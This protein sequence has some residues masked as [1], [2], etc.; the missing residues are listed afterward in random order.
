MSD[1]YAIRIRGP[2]DGIQ[3]I[4]E[5][6]A[7]RIPNKFD[8]DPVDDVQ[9]LCPTNRGPLGARMLNERLQAALNPQPAESLEH[10]GITYAIGD[11]VM[12]TENDYDRD[13]YNGDIGRVVAVDRATR[14]LTVEIDGRPIP[15]TPDD[16]DCLVPAYAIT[17]HK[18][19]GSEYPV[20]VLPL[21]RQ[22][23]RML[24]RNL[25]YTAVTRARRLVVVLAQPDALESAITARPQLRRIS[26]LRDLLYAPSE[27]DDP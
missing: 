8:L 15:Y 4:L 11:K 5:V 19:Q 26:R 2:D 22:Y 14:S 24:R 25:V 3:K 1:F 27:S 17:V 20:I 10:H 13:V 9:V 7:E 16:L 12:Q 6:V 23:G 21:I 18:A